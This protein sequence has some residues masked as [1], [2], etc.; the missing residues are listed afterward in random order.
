M[1]A[2]L[3]QVTYGRLNQDLEANQ[4][5]AVNPGAPLVFVPFDSRPAE[6]RGP[7]GEKVYARAAGDALLG[8]LTTGLEDYN[9]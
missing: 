6:D 7:P 4:L 3:G 8:M 9:Q 1:N 2:I 5:E